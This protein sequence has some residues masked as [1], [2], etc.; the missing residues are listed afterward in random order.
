M[1]KST[2]ALA[3]SALALDLMEQG[4]ILV[5]V[6]GGARDGDP[7]ARSIYLKLKRAAVSLGVVWYY[8]D[9]WPEAP[10]EEGKLP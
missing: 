2:H 5:A 10:A 8:G 1:T 3:T 6:W 4:W 9:P 7:V